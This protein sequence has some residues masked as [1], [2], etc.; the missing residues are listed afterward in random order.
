LEERLAFKIAVDLSFSIPVIMLLMN[1]STAFWPPLKRTSKALRR[2][3]IVS[4]MV[5][6]MSS[7]ASDIGIV[8]RIE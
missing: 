3:V 5:D 7:W 2:Q 4:S 6:T 8:L 1:S